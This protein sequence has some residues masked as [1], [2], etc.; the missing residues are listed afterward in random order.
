MLFPSKENRDWSKFQRPFKEGDI[1]ST[2]SGKWIGI[3]KRKVGNAYETYTT[4]Y[5]GATVYNDDTFCF[6]RL[7]TESEK[8]K[9]FNVIK[10]NGYKWNPDTKTLEKLIE[11]KFK[12]GDRIIRTATHETYI[13]DHITS[14]GY[15]FKNEGGTGFIF[16]DEHLYELAPNKFDITTLKPFD[17]EVLVRDFTS[18]IWLPAFF[19][20]YKK[21]LLYS[22]ITTVGCYLQC[23][24]YEGNEHLI[25]TKEDCD[26]YYKTWEE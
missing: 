8:Q 19:G 12:V 13:I 3:V 14:S 23:I 18:N 1:V 6:E 9:L 11:P 10:K 26:D 4:I 15:I 21:D 22:Y 16:E 24:P 20:C 7:A 17:S 2:K 5:D 25:G